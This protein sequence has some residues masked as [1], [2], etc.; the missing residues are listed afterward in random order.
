MKKKRDGRVRCSELLGGMDEAQLDHL[1]LGLTHNFGATIKRPKELGGELLILE[2]EDGPRI[3]IS[4][5]C[6][7][8]DVWN[9]AEAAFMSGGVP[10]SFMG[11]RN[12]M[13]YNDKEQ[14]RIAHG[15]AS[16]DSRASEPAP[17]R[18]PC[19]VWLSVAN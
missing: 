6:T 12:V 4:A 3:G 11:V 18:V 9:I 1:S 16:L 7:V 19:S 8:K 2:T 10:K 5:G 15:L 14:E 17:R 13:P